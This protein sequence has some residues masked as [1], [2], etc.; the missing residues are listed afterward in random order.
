MIQSL[1]VETPCAGLAKLRIKELILDLSKVKD[2]DLSKV[3]PPSV[4]DLTL[5]LGNEHSLT[6]SLPIHHSL[7][8]LTIKA[9]CFNDLIQI[10]NLCKV[11]GT[12]LIKGL[13]NY[14]HNQL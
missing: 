10:C 5:I 8:S 1:S 4:Q 13:Q 6:K 7:K 2:A 14:G 11:E 9:D 12:L 3:V